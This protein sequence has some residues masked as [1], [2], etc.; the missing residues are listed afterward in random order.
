MLK[1]SKSSLRIA[2]V[3]E[4]GVGKTTIAR[5]FLEKHVNK[6]TKMTIGVEKHEHMIKM[7]GEIFDLTVLDMSGG[8]QFHSIVESYLNRVDA[9]IFVYDVTDRESFAKLPYWNRLVDNSTTG[10]RTVSKILVGNK[11]D[12]SKYGREVRSK[13]AGNYASFE[14]MVYLEASAKND[15]NITLVFQCIANEIVAKHAEESKRLKE[16]RRQTII[17]RKLRTSFVPWIRNFKS[18][19]GRSWNL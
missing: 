14:E 2:L 4:C 6:N 11:K 8:Y 7:R 17:D 15:D 10:Q 12:L 16:L 5:R 13:T 1:S 19:F 18:I 3:G 9:V